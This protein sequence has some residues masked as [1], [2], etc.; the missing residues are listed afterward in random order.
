[1][2]LSVLAQ[3]AG[4]KPE[5]LLK[6]RYVADAQI[7][8]D[9][10]RIAYV[11][12]STDDAKDTYNAAIWLADVRGT[13]SRQLTQ[14]DARDLGP[15]WSRD[16]RRLAFVS[17]RRGAPAQ[18][19]VLSMEGGE[20]VQATKMPNGA[21][22]IEWSQD[23]RSL[24]F[25]SRVG[26]KDEPTPAGKTVPPRTLNRLSF[27]TDGL[28]Y[29]R[30]GFTHI[31]I[32]SADGGE[33]RQ[34]TAG[35]FNDG[36]PAWS[37]D[38]KS[39]A[40]SA[41]RK[42]DAD[43]QLGDSE[44][45][46]VAATG[47]EPRALTD[48]RGPDQAPAWSPDGKRIAYLGND[49]KMLSYTVTRLYVMNADGS[50]KRELSGGYDRSVGDGVGGDVAAPFGGGGERIQW[51]PDGKR[52]LFL[53][54]DQGNSN[55]RAF[56]ADGGPMEEIT[57][58]DREISSFTV[59]ESG[60]VAAVV[61][62]PVDPYDVY[63]FSLSQPALRRLSNVNAENLKGVE[64]QRPEMFWYDSFD[65][66]KIQ[67]WL[68]KPTGFQA[69]KKYPLLLYIHGG[70]HALYGNNFFHEFHVLAAAGYA[71][72]YP[73][74]RGSTGY[75]QEF[76]NVIQYHYPGD[77]YKDLMAGVD[78]LLARGF[79]DEKRMGVMGGSG[80]GVLTSWT[81][82]HTQ[83]FAAAVS[84]RGVYDW[85]SFVMSADFNYTFAKRWFRDFPWNDPEDYRARSSISYVKNITTPLLIIHSEEDYR[86]PIQQGEELYTALKMLK[87]E[88]KMLRFAAESHGL[89]RGGRP[90]NRIAHMKAGLDWM[91]DHLK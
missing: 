51:S 64:I 10:S 73:N 67:G 23:G 63:T 87:R 59:A 18:I 86:V 2:V 75:G 13:A 55:L 61:T 11:Q 12:Y 36:A 16:G 90:S 20:A 38:G 68:I 9:G 84:Q 41:I 17:T 43:Y 33:P 45:Y 66:R 44:I 26:P 54:A 22:N 29:T 81:V 70:P 46:V 62:T 6:W 21:A 79:V 28:G 37:P 47:G 48:R 83:R 34:L 32:V 15:R 40:F 35:D 78:T 58:G 5:S 85:A 57:R 88:V 76:G 65:G 3:A 49:E 77:D 25:T 60:Q 27:R 80:G 24:A 7:S 69:G 91:N 56:P 14:G 4:L 50:G 82:G 1:L 8:P 52:I 30:E 39:I 74:P 19:F 31:F 89:T 72:F 42:P 71:V 53:S